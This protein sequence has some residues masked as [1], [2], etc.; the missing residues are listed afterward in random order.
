VKRSLGWLLVAAL[1]FS[2]CARQAPQTSTAPNPSASVAP[3]LVGTTDDPTTGVIAELYVQA[4]A[5]RG[6]QARAVQFEDDANT[7][8]SRLQAGEADVAPTFAWTAAQSLQVD[9][10]EPDALVSDLAAALDGEVAVLQPSRV[11]RAW[12]YVTTESVKS[13]DALPNGSTVVGNSRWKSAPD[14][15]DGLAAVYRTK[16]AVAIVED[17]DDRL[18]RVQ[19]G[20]TGAFDGTEPQGMDSSLTVL[21][22]PRAMISAD[23]HVALMRIEMSSDDTV[24]E[25]IQQLHAVLDNAS[26]IEIRERAATAGVET[27]VTEWLAEHPLR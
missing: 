19:A 1:V 6:R 18:A 7:L 14:G 9:S 3:V 20:A 11:D 12:R 24:L 17:A 27:A 2:G 26:V 8:V 4:L 15:P 10:D 5:A 16:P 13:L 22:D 21:Q 23:P 25:V